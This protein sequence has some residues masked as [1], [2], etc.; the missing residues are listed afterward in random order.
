MAQAFPPL[1]R[2]D[3][4]GVL[5]SRVEQE[6]HAAVREATGERCPP[7]LRDAI[8]AAVFPGGHRL[9]PLLCLSVARALGDRDP[10]QSAAAAAAVELVHC[11]SL[12]H[13]DLPCFDDAD[14]RRGLPTIHRAFDEATAVLVG[15]A[16]IVA[17]LGW[18][19]RHA[20]ADLVL[21]LTAG[22][23]S[24]RGIIAGQAWEGEP[25][26]DIEEYHRAKTAALFEAAAVM[27]ARSAGSDDPGWARFGEAVG[28]A[29]QAADDLLDVLGSATAAGKTTGRDAVRGR[30]NLARRYGVE[31][32]KKRV[33]M[34]LEAAADLLPP[35]PHTAYAQAWLDAFASKLVSA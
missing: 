20:R 17:G 10:D 32:A 34:Q 13:D 21:A 1:A 4:E 2:S 30:P 27:G 6:L 24:A 31:A 3:L 18:L 33:R 12:V 26:P 15:D 22:L 14:L 5:S 9:R 11:A 19:A 25:D 28:H 16:L 35:A 8:H 29:Y 7:R 23:G